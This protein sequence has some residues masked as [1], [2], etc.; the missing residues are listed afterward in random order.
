MNFHESLTTILGNNLS[1]AWAQAFI[2]SYK[3]TG[4]VLSPGIVSFPVRDQEGSWVLEN[5]TI[6][7]ALEHQLDAFDICSVNQSNI[8][9]VAGTIFPESI[10]K[11][12]NRNRHKL[13]E[14]Y[15]KIWIQVKKCSA[16]NRGTYFRRL[17]SYGN[18]SVNQL[19]TIIDAWNSGTHRR[20]ALQAGIFDP[21]QDHRKG[22]F[23]GFP[24]LQQVV[25][26][27]I[28]PN[29]SEGMTV[30]AFY[31]NQ[32]LLKKAYGNYLGLYRLGK[33]MAAEMGLVLRG[34]TCIASNLKMSDNHGKGE[35]SDFARCLLKEVSNAN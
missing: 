8:E 9:T 18:K 19:E 29:G 28:G 17:T 6:R 23:L 26:H 32:L 11:R 24:C 16:N 13:F 10:W 14:T 27:P 12:C 34:V 15:G 2:K 20:S 7:N 35:C 30:V 25:F 4:G 22:P 21:S 1:D 5:S 31:A 3:V 33:F